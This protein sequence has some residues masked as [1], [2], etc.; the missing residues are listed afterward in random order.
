[1]NNNWGKP[2]RP[3]ETNWSTIQLWPWSWHTPPSP[4]RQWKLL[5]NK[6]LKV[7]LKTT[8]EMDN[9]WW[10]WNHGFTDAKT[11]SLSFRPGSLHHT[12][13]GSSHLGRF[14]G[15]RS[16]S[17]SDPAMFRKDFLLVEF[18]FASFN[19]SISVHIGQTLVL[20]AGF[21]FPSCHVAAPNHHVKESVQE[22]NHIGPQ[23]P[24]SS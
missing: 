8:I 7:T 4:Q 15:I 3:T 20:Q 1:M 21:R 2:L 17:T 18:G 6:M 11:A 22:Q 23:F 19:T 24:R 14:E 10:A 16:W 5:W 12:T 13:L 9:S